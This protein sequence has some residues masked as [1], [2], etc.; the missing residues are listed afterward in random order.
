MARLSS[1]LFVVPDEDLHDYVGELDV[2][3]GFH[4]L[5]LRSHQRGPKA[6]AKVGHSHQVLA[7]V[8]CHP[9]GS[10]QLRAS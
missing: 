6:H 1:D 3:D 7:S 8:V 10:G 5:L 4:G 9:D 2:H